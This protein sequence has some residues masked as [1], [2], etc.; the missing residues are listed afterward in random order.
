[1]V[2]SRALLDQCFFSAQ[3]QL[4]ITFSVINPCGD[5]HTGTESRSDIS[6]FALPLICNTVNSLLCTQ[7]TTRKNVSQLGSTEYGYEYYIL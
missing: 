7:E 1:M 3:S 4:S 6:E 2:L 5:K